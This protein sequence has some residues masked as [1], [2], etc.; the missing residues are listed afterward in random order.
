[1]LREEHKIIKDVLAY[2]SVPPFLWGF[3]RLEEPPSELRLVTFRFPFRADE[4]FLLLPGFADDSASSSS[5]SD[6]SLTRSR[7]VVST[8]VSVAGARGGGG[9][10]GGCGG[11]LGDGS[12]CGIGDGSG[13]SC[14]DA[15]VTSGS[16]ADGGD[17]GGG[18]LSVVCAAAC[19]EGGEVAGGVLLMGTW[20]GGLM[21]SAARAAACARMR[22]RN[23]LGF[24]VEVVADSSSTAVKSAPR[25]SSFLKNNLT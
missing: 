23:P 19:A 12:C 5:I 16:V 20:G 25:P 8:W 13:G 10:T 1:M 24:D 11:T 9:C 14:T 2:A 17:T 22:L 18:I 7:K 15:V 3:L 21:V 6:R 4:F